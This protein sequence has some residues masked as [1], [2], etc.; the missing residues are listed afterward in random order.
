MF[1]ATS[2]AKAVDLL[3]GLHLS[4]RATRGHGSE[5]AE[6]RD[7]IERKIT[8][9]NLGPYRLEKQRVRKGPSS[10]AHQADFWLVNGRVDAALY[11]I[12]G[13]DDDINEIVL[14]DSMPV[15]LEEFR[16]ANPAFRVVAVTAGAA[17]NLGETLA[18]LRQREI[19]VTDL[20]GLDELRDK[21]LPAMEL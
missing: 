5:R 17:S 19:D 21:L 3:A 9:W 4:G 7:R 12:S 16:R 2:L 15:V 11:A 14:R 10:V 1:R 8:G 18:F 20:Q 6:I 13:N